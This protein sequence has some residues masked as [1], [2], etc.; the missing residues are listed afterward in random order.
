MDRSRT[1]AREKLG[2]FLRQGLGC[3]LGLSDTHGGENGT[4]VQGPLVEKRLPLGR[5]PL[6]GLWG[7]FR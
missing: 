3:S 7:M 6:A 2:N 4:R 5:R 1:S